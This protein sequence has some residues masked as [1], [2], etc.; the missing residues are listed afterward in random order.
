MSSSSS[1]S[2]SNQHYKDIQWRLDVCLSSRTL[3][4]Q[5]TPRFTLS[6][7]TEDQN[8]HEIKNHFIESDY[9]TLKNVLTKL[10]AALHA[11]STSRVQRMIK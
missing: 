1:L 7:A 10:E 4:Q 3:R 5:C 9:S 6:L 11:S 8:T 2:L